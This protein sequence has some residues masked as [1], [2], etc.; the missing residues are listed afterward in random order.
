M[1]IIA[2]HA[3]GRALAKPK[4]KGVRPTTDRVRESLFSILGPMHDLVVVDAFAG[5]GALGCE[6][7]SR[8]AHFVFFFD[9]ARQSIA[10]IKDNIG[11]IQSEE[12]TQVRACTFARGLKSIN[13]DVDLLFLDPPYHSDLV[14]RALD[15]LEHH[16]HVRA[17]ARII[18][19]QEIDEPM[20]D[21]NTE[22]FHLEDQRIY[23]RTRLS[24]LRCIDH[25]SMLSEEE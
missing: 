11:R 23:G 14:Q 8:G 13:K 6:A 17:R 7:L 21:F 2:G 16:P 1:R 5:S 19:E 25:E 24:F 4:H 18:I 22:H 15:A 3:K 9:N 10:L 12:Q 20:P